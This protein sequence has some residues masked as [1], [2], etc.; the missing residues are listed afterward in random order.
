MGNLWVVPLLH[1]VSDMWKVCGAQA[2]DE[3]RPQN[4]PRKLRK[5]K[6]SILGRTFSAAEIQSQDFPNAITIAIPELTCM[7]II[8]KTESQGAQ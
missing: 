2:Q 1:S 7:Y 8:Y 3:V 5:A 4:S 6:G